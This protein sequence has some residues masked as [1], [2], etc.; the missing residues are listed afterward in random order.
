MKSD[1]LESPEDFPSLRRIDFDD[2]EQDLSIKIGR[3]LEEIRGRLSVS[4]ASMAH[5]FGVTVGQ[6]RKYEAG[7][8]MPKLHASARWSIIS[9]VPIAMLFHK[10]R[11]VDFLEINECDIE[12]IP[13]YH[14]IANATDHVFYS[15]LKLVFQDSSWPVQE[16]LRQCTALDSSLD[17]IGEQYCQVLSKNLESA[18]A[19]LALGKADM[20]EWL[21][22][23][24]NTY[25]R[26]VC[27]SKKGSM[28]VYLYAR[29]A[30]V[31]GAK[32]S[33]AMCGETTY[34]KLALKRDIR[35]QI[36][37]S[38]LSI[39]KG[40]RLQAIKG[41]F[42]HIGLNLSMYNNPAMPMLNH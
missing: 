29:I 8:D 2:Y 39:E 38:L 12:L 22:I 3:A 23:A 41:L 21:G 31:S 35:I 5:G 9:G 42:S 13:L 18:R 17:G 37:K 40:G 25:S 20:A 11:Y 36:L 15:G 34:S 27:E 14:T 7:I 26:Y 10:T 1:R 4:Q 28:P 19:S 30:A 16:E 6:Y 33:W 32:Q 24:T